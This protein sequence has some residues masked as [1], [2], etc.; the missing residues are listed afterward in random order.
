M[1][2]TTLPDD[3]IITVKVYKSPCGELL[4]GSCSD[5]LCLCDWISEDKRRKRIDNRILRGVQGFFKEGTS[6]TIERAIKE[7]KEYFKGE[8]TQFD[9]PLLTIGTDFQNRVWE[10]LL[11]IPYGST[12]SYGLL[13]AK[14]G[15]PNSVRAVANAN[16]ANAISIFIPCHRIIGSNNS[17]TGYAGGIPAKAYL[18]NLED[19]ST[20]M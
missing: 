1:S 12:M 16:G 3:R 20:K 8:R 14:M 19:K 9:I 17:L 13:A 2:Q 10:E 18:L 15:C 6:P 11:R 5:S 7:L 4:L